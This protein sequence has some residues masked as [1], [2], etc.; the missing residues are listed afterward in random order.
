M[1]KYIKH[2]RE[3]VNNWFANALIVKTKGSTFSYSRICAIADNLGLSNGPIQRAAWLVDLSC[4]FLELSHISEYECLKFQNLIIKA[5]FN[6][7]SVELTILKPNHSVK[8]I[9]WFNNM[10]DR[11]AY[12]VEIFD[13]QSKI[14]TILRRKN[15]QDSRDVA[16][17][18]RMFPKASLSK[19]SKEISRKRAYSLEKNSIS[20]KYA[21]TMS[22]K[23]KTYEAY[24]STAVL[25]GN[26][27]SAKRKLSKRKYSV[28]KERKLIR[29]VIKQKYARSHLFQ[30]QGLL[31]KW[32]LLFPVV[33]YSFTYNEIKLFGDRR[34]FK[35]LNRWLME[36]NRW[37]NF[38]LIQNWQRRPT[39]PKNQS[40]L[41]SES[42]P[43]K[44]KLAIRGKVNKNGQFD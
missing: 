19:K 20:K 6:S 24:D 33:F 3:S 39:R 13:T 17:L 36:P 21:T 5:R 10:F 40:K 18:K 12:S 1:S 30:D 34:I 22:N 11:F 44:R 15:P 23:A 16:E 35:I 42:I 25:M 41:D 28:E 2:V 4:R 27:K 37:V 7:T 32:E 43:P 29:H 8:A 14:K 38:G 26:Y 31:D 9:K